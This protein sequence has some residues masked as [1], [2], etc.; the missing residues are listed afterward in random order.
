MQKPTACARG[1]SVSPGTSDLNVVLLALMYV[2]SSFDSARS[3]GAIIALAFGLSAAASLVGADA[4]R[5]RELI[6]KVQSSS[7]LAEK[8]HAL[9]TLA[10][11]G[12]AEAVPV[13]AGLLGD[14]KLGHYA[15]D[16]LEQ[17]GD[18]TARAAL[19]EALGRLQGKAL[20]GVIGSLATLRDEA[21]AAAL[22]RLADG[23]AD[24]V[25]AATL[26]ALG[27]IGAADTRARL[28]GFLQHAVL[29]RRAAA[30]EGILIHADALVVGGNPAA[31]KVLYSKIQ[32][33]EVPLPWQLAARRGAILTSG[34]EAVAMVVELLRSDMPEFRE[35]ALGVARELGRRGDA[36]L[37]PALVGELSRLNPSWQAAVVT[38]LVELGGPDVLKATEQVARDGQAEARVAAVRAL[39]RMGADSS[40]ALLLAAAVV[41]SDSPLEEAAFAS[42]S[43]I[44][45]PAVEAQVVGLL[46]NVSVS[47]QVRLIGVLG[48]R[49]AQTVTLDLFRLARGS[50]PELAK[51]AFRALGQVLSPAQLPQLI[52]ATMEVTDDPVKVLADRA[53]VTTSMKILEPSRAADAVLRAFH[54]ATDLAAKAA[55]LRPLSAI[56]RT[57]GPNHDVF[58]ALRVALQDPNEAVRAAALTAL[59]EWPNASPALTLLDVA[60]TRDATP[61]VRE[62]AL[63]GAFR[64]IG[65]V[66]AGRERSSLDVVRA[67]QAAGRTVRTKEEKGLYVSAVGSLRRVEGVNLLKPYLDDPEVK[68]EAASALVQVAAALVGNKEFAQVKPLLERLAAGKDVEPEIKRQVAKLVRG[69][70]A[71]PA[72]TKKGVASVAA[73]AAPLAPGQLFNGVDLANWDGDPGVWRVVDGVIVGGTLL[74]NPRNEFLA[75][76]RPYRNFV[77]KVDY[78]LT[79]T[80]GFVNAG[81]QVRSVRIDTPPNEMSG[82]QADIGAGHSGSLYDESRRKKFLARAAA[83]QVKRLEKVGDWNT[84]EIRCEG[85]RVEIRLNG[86]QT[87]IYTE[88]DTSVS[89]DGLIAL[90]IHGNCKAEV[91]YRNLFVEQL[92]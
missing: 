27:R 26:T 43:R 11:V 78:K 19:R 14:E 38:A 57:V 45:A 47:R 33:A 56:M 2:L 77:L 17:L 74:G 68:S 87:L 85:P 3:R 79:G 88:S 30:A 21:A 71:P 6:G 28:E 80:E 13:L 65:N 35:L 82:Y 22:G 18:A 37:T 9:Q 61:A 55:L 16:G 75:T 72:K 34:P 39:G 32:H 76:T 86:E 52:A 20:I 44:Q 59:T 54:E 48:D 36:R 92:P 51:A 31:A 5:T 50:D 84:Y 89:P 29:A 42:L 49:K 91:R 60:A 41:E 58:V 67:F 70:A 15:R 64:M 40:V 73:P 66:A 69:P 46:P 1:R 10:V 83:V 81:V 4:N 12:T 62:L 53:I 24:D 23:S 25:A 63:Q 7:D 90:Q 8:A